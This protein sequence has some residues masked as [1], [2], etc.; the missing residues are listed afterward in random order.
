MTSS[1]ELVKQCKVKANSVKRLH[2]ELMYYEKERDKEQA[3]VDK[4]KADEAIPSDI[5]QAV[6]ARVRFGFPLEGICQISF[7]FMNRKT[8]FKNRL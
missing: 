3:R 8:Y 7:M 2:K 6:R 5:K 1:A 4:M